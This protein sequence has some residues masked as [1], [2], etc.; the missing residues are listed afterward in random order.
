MQE[1]VKTETPE[2]NPQETTQ[3]LTESNRATRRRNKSNKFNKKLIAYSAK[4]PYYW[5]KRI[6]NEMKENAE[7]QKRLLAGEFD[8]FLGTGDG[9][10]KE[11][12]TKQD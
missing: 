7:V 9:T 10:D 11:T 2:T 8:Y 12:E 6:L 4:D 1:D 3:F 5:H